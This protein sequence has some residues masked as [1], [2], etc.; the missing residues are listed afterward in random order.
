MKIGVLMQKTIRMQKKRPHRYTL[1]GIL[2][3][4]KI[5]C[6]VYNKS[7]FDWSLIQSSAE[8]LVFLFL[9][10]AHMHNIDWNPNCFRS[11]QLPIKTNYRNEYVQKCP[12]DNPLLQMVYASTRL[13]NLRVW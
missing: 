10:I 11:V 8:N 1:R 5:V 4:K 2:G 3:V 12:K 7:F 6:A 9:S 13:F